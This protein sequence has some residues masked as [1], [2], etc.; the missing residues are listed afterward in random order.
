MMVLAQEFG[1]NF[2]MYNG[3]SA[4]V[5][6]ALPAESVDLSIYSPPFM[7]LYTYSPSE[8]DIGNC[9]TPAEFWEHMSWVITENLRLTRPG[10]LCCVHVAQVAAML[11]KDGYIGLK[12]F[13]GDT[14]RAY[15][16]GGWIFHGE[17]TVDKNPQIQAVRTKS[18]ALLFVQLHK[19]STWSRPA[20]TDYI[21]IFRK[22]GENHVPVVPDISNE[23]W[24]EW[25]HGVWYGIR[26]MDTLN[27]VDA[28]EDDDERHMAALQLSLI[29]RCV[30]LW[31]NPGEVI[32]SPFA[33]IGSEGYVA[34]QQRR[35]FIGVELKPSYY[36]IAVKNLQEA[37]RMA[38]GGDLFSWAQEMGITQEEIQRGPYPYGEPAQNANGYHI[39]VPEHES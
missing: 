33:G 31:T 15:E 1:Q 38:R 23:T 21:L 8:R 18:K 17:V 30:R 29:E 12:D 34:L 9:R 25:A 4:E 22:P 26:E 13:R 14:I 10:R 36:R 24:I 37:E 39:A 11:S 7:S 5:M 28:R 35:R 2:G 3:D 32:L 19:D 20:M 27:P 16:A 6:A